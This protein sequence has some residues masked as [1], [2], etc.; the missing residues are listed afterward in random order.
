MGYASREKE[1]AGEADR[2]ESERE[3]KARPAMI[4]SDPIDKTQREMREK[5]EV[6]TESNPFQ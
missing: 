6:R 4:N 1:R 2:S 3:R 5:K